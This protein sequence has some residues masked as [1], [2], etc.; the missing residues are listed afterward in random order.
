MLICHP[1]ISL[2]KEAVLSP[3]NFGTTH[4]TAFILH[5]CLSF[6][7][8]PMKWRSL[9]QCPKT[10]GKARRLQLF[11]EIVEILEDPFCFSRGARE[12]IVPLVLFNLVCFRLSVPPPSTMHQTPPPRRALYKFELCPGFS[13]DQPVW[14]IHLSNLLK[15]GGQQQ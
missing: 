13:W 1:V 7:S 4:L 11:L 3:F 6:T 8:Q 5:F 12:R 9:S 10:C 14:S 15:G 2:Q